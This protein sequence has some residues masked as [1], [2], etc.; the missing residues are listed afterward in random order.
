MKLT[1]ARLIRHSRT[2]RDI[3]CDYRSAIAHRCRIT[4]L[5]G[6]LMPDF[7][8]GHFCR[9]SVQPADISERDGRRWEGGMENVMLK[10]P[11]RDCGKKWAGPN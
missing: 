4:A 8:E 3:D 7:K 6:T 11:Y 10:L 1:Q 9:L 5:G 2:F